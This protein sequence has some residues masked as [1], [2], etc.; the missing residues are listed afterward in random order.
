MTME[1]IGNLRVNQLEDLLEGLSENAKEMENEINGKKKPL[2]GDSA[3][4]A[5]IG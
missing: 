1:D 4:K 2:E 5:L 3:L